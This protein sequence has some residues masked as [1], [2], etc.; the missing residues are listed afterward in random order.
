MKGLNKYLFVYKK[1][2]HFSQHTS[3]IY[4]VSLLAIMIIIISSIVMIMMIITMYLFRTS[5]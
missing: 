4:K 5:N 2:A 3:K 1:V